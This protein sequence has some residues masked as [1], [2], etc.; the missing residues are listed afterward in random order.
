MTRRYSSASTSK[1]CIA[2]EKLITNCNKPEN[3]P[4]IR[5][6]KGEEGKRAGW[7]REA[8]VMFVGSRR[9][10]YLLFIWYINDQDFPILQIRTRG[11]GVEYNWHPPA[12]LI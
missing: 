8:R 7:L 12:K 9:V 3:K 2:L 6:D 1:L 10:F 11:L 4:E 5:R